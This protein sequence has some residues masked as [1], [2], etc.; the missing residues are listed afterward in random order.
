MK[1]WGKAPAPGRAHV[2][3]GVTEEVTTVTQLGTL[4]LRWRVRGRAQSDPAARGQGT[5]PGI[6][7]A[8]AKTCVV[9]LLES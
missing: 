3:Q 4:G 7:A 5:C 9:A 8:R 1:V 6:P 2:H